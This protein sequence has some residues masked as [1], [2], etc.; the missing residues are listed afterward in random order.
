MSSTNPSQHHDFELEIGT[1]LVV[2]PRGAHHCIP[3]DKTH[4]AQHFCHRSAPCYG[5]AR[6]QGDEKEEDRKDTQSDRSFWQANRVQPGHAIR[7]VSTGHP[8]D[9]MHVKGAADQSDAVSFACRVPFH[10]RMRDG[11]SARDGDFVSLVPQNHAWIQVGPF[12]A[13]IKP[14]QQPRYQV[15]GTRRYKTLCMMQYFGKEVHSR[16]TALP[17]GQSFLYHTMERS[18]KST[19]M[20]I[21]SPCRIFSKPLFTSL[22]AA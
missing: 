18:E 10:D 4:Q 9:G 22:P 5:N 1:V 19:T 8:A 17:T 11:K 2:E 21:T 12:E 16:R 14:C 7:N 6:A 13:F 3:T 15:G 20:I